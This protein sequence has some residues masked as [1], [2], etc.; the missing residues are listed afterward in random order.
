MNFPR[1]GDEE[2]ELVQQPRQPLGHPHGSTRGITTREANPSQPASPS[3]RGLSSLSPAALRTGRRGASTASRAAAPAP[4][5]PVS[6]H[7]QP[8]LPEPLLHLTTAP[9]PPARSQQPRSASCASAA[10]TSPRLRSSSAQGSDLTQQKR[11]QYSHP[12]PGQNGVEP[13]PRGRA[14][15]ISRR[16]GAGSPSGVQPGPRPPAPSRTLSALPTGSGCGHA[17]W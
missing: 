3:L 5:R 4:G 2:R 12:G 13:A 1:P 11:C 16:R 9:Q 15:P 10:L 17:T 7:R 8:P 6:P 14:P